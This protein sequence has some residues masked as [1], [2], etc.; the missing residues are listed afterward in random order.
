MDIVVFTRGAT[1][2]DKNFDRL[3]RAMGSGGTRRRLLGWIAAGGA[4]AAVGGA[5]VEESAARNKNFCKGKPNACKLPEEDI[6]DSLCGKV[7][8]KQECVCIPNAEGNKKCAN[9]I[10]AE[11]P[12]EDECDSSKDCRKDEV[13]LDVTDCCEGSPK[14]LCAPLCPNP[15]KNPPPPAATASLGGLLGGLLGR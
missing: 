4:A 1:V 11:C 15:S 8:N 9:I 14:S 12:V 13:C 7:T 6:E 5:A 3:T 2:D 10:D